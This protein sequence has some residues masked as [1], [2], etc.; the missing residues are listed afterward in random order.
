MVKVE[1]HPVMSSSKG[2]RHAIGNR[3]NMDGSVAKGEKVVK[4]DFFG[5]THAGDHS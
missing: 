5:L 3:L 1:A 2:K 4:L